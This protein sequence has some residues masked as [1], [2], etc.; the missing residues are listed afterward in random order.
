MK[1]VLLVSDPIGGPASVQFD[2]VG[3]LAARLRSKYEVAL[4]TPYIDPKRRVALE[5]M[6]VSVL[7]QGRGFLLDRLLR[8]GAADNESMLWAES[9]V[10]QAILGKNAAEAEHVVG[11][12]RFDYV[13]NL[14]MTVPVGS[15]LWWILG[16]PLDQTLRGMAGMNMVANL[17]GIVGDGVLTGLDD[18]LLFEIQRR[19]RHIVANSPYLRDLHRLR[20]VPVEG[21]VYTLTEMSEF[22][23]ADITPKRDYVLMYL[24]KE[25]EPI[26]FAAL[27]QAGLRIVAFGSKIPAGS[28]FRHVQHLLDFRGRVS[29]EML[30]ALY[31]GAL[32]TLFPFTCEPMGLVPIESM[33]CGTPVLTY[34]RQGPASTV[35][36]GVTGWLVDSQDQMMRK[37][38][39][40][41]RRG[42]TGILPET[43]I[44]RAREFTVAR[45]VE[46]LVTWIEGP[47]GSLPQPGPDIG[48]HRMGGDVP[49]TVH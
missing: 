10:R 23:P 22:G 9:W 7:G 35:L 17:A 32:F 44:Q 49:L 13:V 42:D 47:R 8:L 45:S 38:V 30:V 20:G 6:G 41:W 33:A 11:R 12:W 31:S 46:E 43:C 19:A 39:E 48:S 25:T 4:Y 16:T 5:R 21:V 15:D 18:R 3:S 37:A 2:L 34:N 28:R 24:G 26:D 29:R 36:N 1:T 40:L 27:K 14:S